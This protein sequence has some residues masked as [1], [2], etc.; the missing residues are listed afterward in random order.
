MKIDLTLSGLSLWDFAPS[1]QISNALEV[2]CLCIF[3]RTSK[4]DNNPPWAISSQ[5]MQNIL[6]DKAIEKLVIVLFMKYCVIL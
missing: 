5:N 3:H 4:F 2:A 6:F 1:M